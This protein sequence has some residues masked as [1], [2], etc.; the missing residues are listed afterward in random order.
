MVSQCRLV[1]C[2]LTSGRTAD[3]R[4]DAADSKEN[5]QRAGNRALPQPGMSKRQSSDLAP[6]TQPSSK[7]AF[8]KTRKSAR[9]SETR[10]STSS[11][12]PDSQQ[13][14]PASDQLTAQ[15]ATHADVNAGDLLSPSSSAAELATQDPDA[16]DF[17]TESAACQTSALAEPA[18]HDLPAEPP[19]QSAATPVKAAQAKASGD[20]QAL[21]GLH[22][23]QTHKL[24][25]LQRRGKCKES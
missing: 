12:R 5:Q 3:V 17:I 2:I 9:L 6:G 22:T 8:G 19:F 14:A 16:Q 10:T 21:F 18:S 15:R 4:S 11:A 20:N 25:T 23:Q 13:A 7:S 24:Q 1:V